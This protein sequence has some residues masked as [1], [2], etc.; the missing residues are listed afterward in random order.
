MPIAIITNP[1]MGVKSPPAARGI[2]PCN[3]AQAAILITVITGAVIAAALF[4]S[5]GAG[6]IQSSPSRNR[7]GASDTEPP[8]QRPYNPLKP[9]V[10]I[11]F[12]GEP[13]WVTG[14]SG[15]IYKHYILDRYDCDVYG[16]FGFKTE[17]NTT[18]V[19]VFKAFYNPIAV[20]TNVDEDF[21]G[22]F[23]R[24][25]PPPAAPRY[26]SLFQAEWYKMFQRQVIMM[27]DSLRR[28]AITFDRTRGS[29][30]YDWI[31]RA[32]TDSVL[33]ALPNLTTLPRGYLY[34]GMLHLSRGIPEWLRNEFYILPGNVPRAL[35]LMRK[36]LDRMAPINLG[37][38]PSS[39]VDETI[40]HDLVYDLG[41]QNISRVTDYIQNIVRSFRFCLHRSH[42][43]KFNAATPPPFP[44]ACP[45]TSAEHARRNN[46]ADLRLQR[47]RSSLG[48]IRLYQ[49]R[50]V[51]ELQPH[52]SAVVPYA[53]RGHGRQS[54]R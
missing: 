36:G 37:E 26:F 47:Q 5:P 50:R 31:L 54:D 49:A 42:D 2:L 23:A 15:N 11:L 17:I 51:L 41:L 14:I 22:L 30:E 4:V 18:Q 38:H 25:F 8:P 53:R 6:G 3:T 13:R 16:S 7:L 21:P 29:R 35:D 24:M 52:S 43:S 44:F 1:S 19:E 20:D 10:A 9:R 46:S 32:R 45:F 12:S 39:F 34:F 27:Y 28:V 33:T 48:R 40:F